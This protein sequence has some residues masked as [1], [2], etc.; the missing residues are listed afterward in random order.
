MKTQVTQ[1]N[2][3]SENKTI[4][5]LPELPDTRVNGTIAKPY[6]PPVWQIETEQEFDEEEILVGD[7][8]RFYNEDTKRYELGVFVNL[9][10]WSHENET[11]P[12][13]NDTRVMAYVSTR[14]GM[15]YAD[16]ELLTLASDEDVLEWFANW[17]LAEV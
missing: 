17:F 7:Y 15:T 13:Y 3:L 9:W 4:Y 11:S 12:F 8:V 16:V 1:I 14:D 5:V 6:L 10:Q 2:V